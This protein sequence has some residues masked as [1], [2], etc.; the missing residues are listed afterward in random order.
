MSVLCECTGK[1]YRFANYQRHVEKRAHRQFQSQKSKPCVTIVC[2]CGEKY[3][4][5]DMWHHLDAFRSDSPHSIWEKDQGQDLSNFVLI[6]CQCGMVLRKGDW[7]TDFGKCPTCMNLKTKLTTLD[8]LKTEWA[9][10][11]SDRPIKDATVRIYLG[12]INNHFGEFFG[13]NNLRDIKNRMG[14]PD[15]ILSRLGEMDWS[16]SL[17]LKFLAVLHRFYPCQ[18]YTQLYS[19]LKERYRVTILSQREIADFDWDSKLEELCK[20]KDASK[21]EYQNYLISLLL[22]HHP[23]R[24]YDYAAMYVIRDAK[25]MKNLSENANYYVMEERRFIFNVFKNVKSATAGQ[26]EVTL[27]DDMRTVMEKWLNELN[28]SENLLVN[29][30]GEPLAP[31]YLC[32]IIKR[33]GLP[34][35]TRNRKLQESKELANGGNL[36]ETSKKFNHSVAS[37][38]FN[39]NKVVT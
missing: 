11:L 4:Y 15:V 39:Y 33:C 27:C 18:K 23:R 2:A 13:T 1:T 12:M 7:S 9:L 21:W 14:D 25:R 28:L 5:D 34:T 17:K 10:N 22:F 8:E 36:V 6:I 3:R 29:K 20:K 35:T 37:Q 38:Q 30:N 31:Y 16:I 32:K 19:D 26:K 24:L